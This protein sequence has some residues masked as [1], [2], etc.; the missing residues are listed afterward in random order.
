MPIDAV[1]KNSG[2]FCDNY[3]PQTISRGIG[4]FDKNKYNLICG[5]QLNA[6][7]DGNWVCPRCKMDYTE[8]AMESLKRK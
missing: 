7:K 4:K 6:K 8:Q 3:Y 2:N 5:G 1:N